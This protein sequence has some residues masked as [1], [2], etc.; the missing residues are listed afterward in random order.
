MLS[1]PAEVL[2]VV[3]HAQPRLF[4]ACRNCCIPGSWYGVEGAAA[5]EDAPADAAVVASHK[6]TEWCFTFVAGFAL[7]VI[8]PVVLPLL[9]NLVAWKLNVGV[10]EQTGTHE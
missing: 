6:H 2:T 10:V 4:S 5:A 9:C 8:N 1:T 3:A 7:C